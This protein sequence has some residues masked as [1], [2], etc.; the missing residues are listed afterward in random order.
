MLFCNKKYISSNHLPLL[1]QYLIWNCLLLWLCLL[2]FQACGT[3]LYGVVMSAFMFTQYTNSLAKSLI[4]SMPIWLLCN[5]SSICPCNL[6]GTIIILAFIAVPSII[7]GSCL[8]DP[9]FCMPCSTVFLLSDEHCIMVDFCL[10]RSASCWVATCM[11]SCGY[12]YWYIHWCDDSM[13][14]Y[15]HAINFL[16]HVFCM[17]VLG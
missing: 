2:V 16:V 11:P 13:H 7:A 1:A 6:K 4:F 3:L 9:F 15:A 17:V 14:V 8:I 5:C 10:W 12:A